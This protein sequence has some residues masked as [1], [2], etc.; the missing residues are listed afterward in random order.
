LNGGRFVLDIGTIAQVERKLLR[1]QFLLRFEDSNPNEGVQFS[2]T[3]WYIAALAET[4]RTEQARTLFENILNKANALGLFSECFDPVS[5]EMWGNFPHVRSCCCCFC[6][7]KQRELPSSMY[8][9][10]IIVV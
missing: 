4:G 10:S 2:N 3:L 9:P 7:Y 8:F 5:G 1:G 6:F